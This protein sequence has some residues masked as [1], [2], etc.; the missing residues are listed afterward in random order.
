MGM[1]AQAL[2]SS[3]TQDIVEQ[4]DEIADI[5]R[6]KGYKVELLMVV[7]STAHAHILLG[8][9]DQAKPVQVNIPLFQQLQHLF[10]NF[11]ILL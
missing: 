11:L 1:K 6:Q 8:H 2:G 4:L 10:Q 3:V 7:F 9:L 5:C